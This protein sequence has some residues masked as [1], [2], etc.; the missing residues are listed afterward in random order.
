MMTREEILSIDRHCEEQGLSLESYF[1]THPEVHRW[2]YYRY[3]RRYREEDGQS[4]ARAVFVQLTPG[5][6]FVS[7]A[8][9]PS[10]SSGKSKALAQ[11]YRQESHLTVE[12]LTPSG[13]SMRI[14]GGMTAE[15]LHEIMLMSVG[16][17]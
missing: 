13:V 12:P 5:G 9:P 8:V 4:P 11:G 7:G 15:H 10:R 17:V 2:A 6:E 14:Q 1:A 16:N 3:E